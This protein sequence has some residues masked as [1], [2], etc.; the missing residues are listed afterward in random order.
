[1]R[2]AVA[3]Q[4]RVRTNFAFS[5]QLGQRA[6]VARVKQAVQAQQFAVAVA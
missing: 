5:I 2:F 1:V 4:P 3:V 6:L